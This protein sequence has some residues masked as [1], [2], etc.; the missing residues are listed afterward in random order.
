MTPPRTGLK[1]PQQAHWDALYRRFT[2]AGVSWYQ[3]QARFSLALVRALELRADTPVLDVG[4]GASC[5]VDGLIA[6]GFCD[7]SVL[8]IS[9]AALDSARRRLGPDSGVHWI[10]E[11]VLSWHTDRRYGLWHDR[12]VY[13]FLT[14]PRD[15]HSYREAL[16]EA[17]GSPGY[18]ILGTFAPDGPEACSGL[19][20]VRY[21]V[22]DLA[23]SLGPGFRVVRACRELHLTP[24]GKVQPFTWVSAVAL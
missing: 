2:P 16:A 5:F 1:H 13:H 22:E 14:S 12:A 9:S 10:H 4:G 23:A 7:V 15:Q 17:V 19:P 21:G 6:Q 24:A 20:V 11:D 8:D 3:P 18:V